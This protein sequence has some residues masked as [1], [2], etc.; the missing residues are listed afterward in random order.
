MPF[1]SPPSSGR[2]AVSELNTA[3]EVLFSQI[4]ARGS[5]FPALALPCAPRRHRAALTP[6]LW[7]HIEQIIV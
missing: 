6:T 7:F 5:S 4:T 3:P 1:L 2:V